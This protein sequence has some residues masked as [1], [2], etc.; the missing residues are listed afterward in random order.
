MGARRIR[1]PTRLSGLGTSSTSRRRASFS[2]TYIATAIAGLHRIQSPAPAKWAMVRASATIGYNRGMW[3]ALLLFALVVGCAR[4]TAGTRTLPSPPPERPLRIGQLV[5]DPAAGL[6]LFDCRQI[7]KDGGTLVAIGIRPLR[8]TGLGWVHVAF[9]VHGG[10][11]PLRPDPWPMN[12]GR[13]Y[14]AYVGVYKGHEPPF[15]D[16]YCAATHFVN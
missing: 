6:I 16:L 3:R 7:Y 12:N 2:T 11:P 15:Q 4:P 1:R 8:R 14:Y 10:Y 9:K 13:P 5:Q